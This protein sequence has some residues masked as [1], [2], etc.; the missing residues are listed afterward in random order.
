MFTIHEDMHLILSDKIDS[1]KST[2]ILDLAGRL[3]EDGRKI[4]GWITPAHMEGDRKAGHDLILISKGEMAKPIP[5]TRTTPFEESFPWR[6]FHF[7]RNAFEL[8]RG[9]DTKAEI[10]IMDEI[11]PLELEEGEGFIDVV[12]RALTD[13]TTTI[14]VVRSGLEENLIAMI[15]NETASFSLAQKEGLVE[16]LDLRP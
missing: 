5:F 1:G 2:F 11:G 12:M 15:A 7:N 14:S 6:R 8:A 16:A 4:S 10:F 3:I 9:L 13:A